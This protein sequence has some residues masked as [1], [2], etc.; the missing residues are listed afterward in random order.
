MEPLGYSG[1]NTHTGLYV[2]SRIVKNF[3]AIIA[4]EA[5]TVSDTDSKQLQYTCTCTC[6]V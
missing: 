2:L 5:R 1:L 4:E 6:T 3:I